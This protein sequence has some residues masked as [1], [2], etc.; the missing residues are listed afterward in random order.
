MGVPDFVACVDD[1]DVHEHVE[2]AAGVKIGQPGG[3]TILP[4]RRRPI[5]RP[6]SLNPSTRTLAIAAVRS[7]FCPRGMADNG[8]ETLAQKCDPMTRQ[9]NWTSAFTC[10]VP[11]EDSGPPH[12]SPS[13]PAQRRGTRDRWIIHKDR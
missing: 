7:D 4:P 6:V 12:R 3:R 11:E 9:L 5:R 8:R 1:L 13:A 2:L 10:R